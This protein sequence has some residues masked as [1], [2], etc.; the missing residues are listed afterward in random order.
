MGLGRCHQ[1]HAAAMIERLASMSASTW[2]KLAFI[3]LKQGLIQ[4]K[5]ALPRPQHQRQARHHTGRLP[6]AP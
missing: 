4:S 5:P 6:E 2:S 3:E 1:D